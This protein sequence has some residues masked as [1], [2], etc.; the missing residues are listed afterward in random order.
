MSTT[1]P[2]SILPSHSAARWLLF[3]VIIAGIYFFHGFIVPV[4]AAL[5]IAFA[6]WTLYQRLLQLCGGRR[7]LAAAIA[8]M[9]ILGVLI[10]P[11]TMAFSFALEEAQS[12]MAWLVEANRDGASVP[13]WIAALPLVGTW[14][15]E[16]WNEYLNH[17]MRSAKSS[18]WPAVSTWAI[19]PG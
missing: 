9:L 10:V 13:G 8:I 11:L 1:P 7:T 6:S 18:R 4:L 15:A 14:L 16:Q 3:L 17:P 5:I 2:P 12:W 19:S